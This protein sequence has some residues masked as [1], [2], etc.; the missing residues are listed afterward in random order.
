MYKKLEFG[1]FEDSGRQNGT[2]IINFSDTNGSAK[3]LEKDG[4]T[5]GTRWLKVK[6]NEANGG[7]MVEGGGFKFTPS[8]KPEGCTT[9]FVGNLS[10]YASEEELRELFGKCGEITDVRLAKDKETGELKGF[11]HVEFASSDATEGAVKLAG[12]RLSGR[13]IRVDYAGGEKTNSAP[14]D[15]A[16]Y[17]CGQSGHISRECP[18]GSSK[19]KGPASGGKGGFNKKP[20]SK[21]DNGANNKKITF[22]D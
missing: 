14:K 18:S 4:A 13:P 21:I 3:A 15:R 12:T 10:Y 8:K 20:F 9:V 1:I 19:G 22:D 17:V 2:V 16:C 11:G 5:F 6:Y 7:G